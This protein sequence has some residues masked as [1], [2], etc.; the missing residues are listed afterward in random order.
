MAG[1]TR[2][3][4]AD[5]INGSE[6]TA[7]PLNAEF[8]QVAAAF[9]AASGHSHD[10]STGN[11]PK[12]DLTTSVSGYLPAVHGGTGGK[13]NNTATSNPTATDDA[14]EGYAPMSMWENT[15][16]GR[17][18]ICV[19][20]T[21]NAAVWRELV[22]VQTGNK[23][24]PEATNTVDL[25]DPATRFQDL[26]LSGGLSAFG[27]GSL[28]GT[29]SVTGA[30]ALSS[31]LAVT[32]NTSLTG[33]L[34]VVGATSLANLAVSGTTNLNGNTV[35]GNAIS[36]TIAYTGRVSTGIMPSADDAV[37]LGSASNEWRNLYIDGIANIDDLVAD[38]VDINAGAIDNTTIGANT[39]VSA[40]FDGL[41]VTGAVNMSGAAVSNLGSVATVDI[42]G[43]TIDG[44]AL[45][46]SNPITEAT[47]DN[48]KIDGNS[49]TST[50]TDGNLN[51]TPNGTGSV[52]VSK[53]DANSGTIDGTAIGSTVAATGA[54]TTLSTSGQA[55][56]NSAVITGGTIN[57]TSIGGT[58]PT[59]GAFTTVSASAGFTGDVT[60]NL[61]GNVAGNVT[62]DITGN[63]TGD[64]S[65][66]VTSTGTSTFNNV[67]VNGQLNMDAATAATIINLTDPTNAQDAATKSY[68]DTSITNLID[69]APSTLD[70]LNELAAALA[71]DAN[72]YGTLDTK[73]NTKLSKAGDTMTGT[74]D[75]GANSVTTTAAP[76]GNSELTN[77]AYVD[78][79]R[80]T[81]VAKA[82]DTM[83]G[84]L[85]MGSNKVT[86]LA[87]P[88]DG[89]DAAN[90]TYVDTIHGSAVAA[91]TSATNAATS[92]TNAAGS[93]TAAAGS[94]TA[95]AADLVTVQGLY[96][97]FDD[98][99][100]GSHAVAPTVDNDGDALVV[101][102]LFFDSAVSSMKVYSASGWVPA[103]SSVNGTS[104][105]F[106]YTCTANQ[107]TFS[108]ADDN[109]N[110]LEYDAGYLDI[111]VNG[112]KL[113]NGSDFTAT[114][115]TSIQLLFNTAEN[116]ILEVIA[117]GTF[118]LA[119][120]EMDDLNDVTTAGITNG[121]VLKYDTANSQFIAGDADVVADAVNT[122]A[123]QDAA[124]TTAK[125]ADDG[126]TQAKIAAGAI[127]DTEIGTVN[128]TAIDY[129]NTV[130]GISANTVQEAID[131]LNTLSGGSS[132]SVASYTR[133]K[134]VATAG[135]TTF[136]TSNGYT[137]GYL[138]VFVNG[139]LLD[140]TDYTA[141]DSSTV[142][143]TEAADVG[144]E[145]VAIALDSFAIAELLRVTSV[146]PSAPDNSITVGTSGQLGVGNPTPA[147]G[148]TK[149]SV[150]GDVATTKKP[151]VGIVDTTN[152]A[153]LTL[154]GLAPTLFMDQTGGTNGKILTDATGLELK[155]GNLDSEGYRY[156]R[157]ENGYTEFASTGSV[158]VVINA[159]TDNI[160]ETH[161]P[162]LIFKQDGDVDHLR[163]GV[164]GATDDGIV[165]AKNNGSYI[166]ASSSNA[167]LRSLAIGTNDEGAILID[168]YQRVSTPH[169]PAFMAYRAASYAVTS[170]GDIKVTINTATV[171]RGNYYD[172]ANSRFT[173]PVDGLY[174]FDTSISVY[175]TNA[176]SLET[177]DDSQFLSL[178]VNGAE[179]GRNGGSRSSMLNSAYLTKSGVE[180]SATFT[181]ILALSSGDYVEVEY[182]DIQSTVT[183]SNANFNGFFLG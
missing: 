32:G 15:T 123:V 141:N 138:Q 171:N 27:N 178:R 1:Y 97:Q 28:G 132:G 174:K 155:D 104:Q 69:G 159:D 183:I 55:T 10:G 118:T 19:G 126:V 129:S 77:K 59:T 89:G 62:G 76:T 164:A 150:G 162:R 140:I 172:A 60:G 101:G 37:D 38:Q 163:I 102:A 153:S 84:D 86:G 67:T 12:I 26:W 52:V 121:Q 127:G 96:D 114:T 68:V 107:N 156:V 112:V 49:I 179:L 88:T 85:A 30:T 115:G 134:F 34:G 108:G 87:A 122:A 65:G 36:D 83:S 50:N 151:T 79:Q 170:P 39:A 92:E 106:K 41:T 13:S 176:T 71:D 45:G 94:A 58:T 81:R 149:L 143:L 23:I 72:A 160:T 110:S 14:S 131:Y 167:N 16:T 7:P 181:A 124:I 31:T 2:Q 66:N 35:L 109:S 117:Y 128:A 11:A 42:N 148:A 142:V 74:L 75:M 133:D 95:A 168:G 175:A 24:I 147:G 47:V 166:N 70:T 100:L 169:Q 40:A 105:R 22:Q 130:S 116:D 51:L 33:T 43:G 120:M 54:F 20:N 18:F 73:I 154:R 90:K 17:V 103:G 113:V 98:R 4:I 64:I 146:S 21:N 145:V 57:G 125:I 5:I 63:V 80:D 177:Q 82:G 180:M 152:G 144:D 3:S 44:A 25:G 136:T 56:L 53:I 9:A 99:Y 139:I 6:V 48:V 93:A 119:D 91:A 78:T 182:G 135:Q 137:L 111:Y 157:L 161:T 158:D 8:N 46:A 61:A 29:L 173:A 165:G